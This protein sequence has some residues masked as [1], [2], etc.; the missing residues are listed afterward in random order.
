[1]TGLRSAEK[2]LSPVFACAE[3]HDKGC[4]HSLPQASIFEQTAVLSEPQQQALDVIAASCS[5]RPLPK[6]VQAP[7]G[8]AVLDPSAAWAPCDRPSSFSFNARQALLT[9][10]SPARC[11]AQVLEEAATPLSAPSSAGGPA[12]PAAPA[13]G[14]AAAAA[15]TPSGDL[16]SF[17]G[18]SFE[19]VV[20]Q[21]SAE[22]YRWLAELETA[23][24]SETEEKFRRY[25]GALQGH[26]ET[27]DGLL[28]KVGCTCRAGWVVALMQV[29]M[30]EH[31]SEP[32]MPT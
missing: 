28:A 5:Q 9:P 24:S 14:A 15:G 13:A 17:A 20:L 10:A 26:L 19:D 16:P 1:M 31:G 4:S 30:V 2:H 25:G 32:C 27:C 23:R 22:F 3:G 29:V 6:Q 8:H 12:G 7:T 18:T 21:N 11:A